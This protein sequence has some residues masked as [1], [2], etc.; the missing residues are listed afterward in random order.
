M[1]ADELAELLTHDP[2]LDR[3]DPDAQVVLLGGEGSTTAQALADRRA[4]AR[5]VLLANSDVNLVH[6]PTLNAETIVVTVPPERPNGPG[7][8]WSLVRPAPLGT[9]AADT[10]GDGAPV[11][12]S[13]AGTDTIDAPSALEPGTHAPAAG[14]EPHSA[15]GSSGAPPAAVPDTP[16]NRADAPDP[17][18]GTGPADTGSTTPDGTAPPSAATARTARE[19][20]RPSP[21]PGADAAAAPPDAAAAPVPA[22]AGSSRPEGGTDDGEFDRRVLAV[23][24]DRFLGAVAAVLEQDAPELSPGTAALDVSGPVT[25]DGLRDWLDRRLSAASDPAGPD[26]SVNGFEQ[27]GITSLLDRD[28]MV[29]IEELTRLGADL[30]A[31]QQA[32]AVLQG[33]RLQVREAGLTH[34]QQLR[35][36]LSR[37]GDGGS[38]P[39]I[40]ALAE[41]LASGLG[42]RL[43]LADS[44]GNRLTFG[45]EPNPVVSLD[46]HRLEVLSQPETAQS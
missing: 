9:G 17:A 12:T 5:N 28:Y 1:P 10:S 43:R 25:A 20:G 42:V 22:P 32:H 11:I 7:E 45:T 23:S 31:S 35:L 2:H 29:T 14:P 30:T 41:A 13:G 18:D 16:G 44:S 3:L 8:D 15:D 26:A 24:A 40:E 38:V 39:F 27:V 36:L 37:S 4:T 19:T 34:P 46:V 21:G 6:D 33:G